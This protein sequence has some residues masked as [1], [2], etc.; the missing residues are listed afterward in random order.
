MESTN[1][2][3]QRQMIE[4]SL[5]KFQTCGSIE[6]EHPDHAESS[7]SHNPPKAYCQI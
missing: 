4:E 5:G 1:G 6:D 3:H 7:I 2:M